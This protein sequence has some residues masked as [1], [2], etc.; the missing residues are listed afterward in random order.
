[1]RKEHIHTGAFLRKK[2][3]MVIDEKKTMRARK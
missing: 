1:M 2:E 3:E